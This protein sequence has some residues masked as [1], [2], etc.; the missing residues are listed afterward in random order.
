M[1]FSKAE[2]YRRRA[3]ECLYLSR[4]LSVETR[5]ILIDMAQGWL[6]L[7]EEQDATTMPPPVAGQPKPVAQQQQQI[8]PK[9][10]RKD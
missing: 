4:I 10:D 5:S 7:A 8:Q 2:E 3:R 6:R 1:T 9:D